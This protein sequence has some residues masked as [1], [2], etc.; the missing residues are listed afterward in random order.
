MIKHFAPNSP[1][2]F[3]MDFEKAAINAALLVFQC[4][5]SLSFF[6]FSQSCRRRVQIF[7][8]V[9][10]WY[11]E[12]FRLSFKKMQALA[13]LSERDVV[14]GFENFKIN[15]PNNFK[16]ILTWLENNYFGKKKIIHRPFVW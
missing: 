13:F 16:P 11:Y 9:K 2:N 3:N 1:I 5:I 12:K 7:G 14:R 8:L 15:A 4:E 10:Q 6:R